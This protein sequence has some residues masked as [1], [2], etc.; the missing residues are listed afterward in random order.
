M[1]K[2]ATAKLR[3]LRIA[4]RKVRL[5]ADLIRMMNVKEALAILH[6]TPKKAAKPVYKL[7]ASAVANAKN[8]QDMDENKLYISKITVDEGP[9]MKRFRPR[10]MGRAYQILKRT[11][12]INIELKEKNES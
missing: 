11:S 5:V 8:N 3:H 2:Q 9:K 12:H 7:L 10:A 6:V 4:P 1:G